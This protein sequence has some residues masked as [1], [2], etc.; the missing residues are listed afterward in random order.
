MNIPEKSLTPSLEGYHFRR[1]TY[2]VCFCLITLSSSVQT[3]DLR[4]GK[5]CADRNHNS[6]TVSL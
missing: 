1:K 2:L 5:M 4:L 3:S 6:E